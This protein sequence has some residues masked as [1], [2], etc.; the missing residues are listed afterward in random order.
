MEEQFDHLV[1]S[2]SVLE[3]VTVGKEFCNQ[4]ENVNEI[5]EI[6]ETNE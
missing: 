1:Y 5:I 4:I 3:F 6:N 2:K